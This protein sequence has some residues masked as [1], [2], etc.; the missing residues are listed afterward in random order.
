MGRGHPSAI[1]TRKGGEKESGEKSF[2]LVFASRWI[3]LPGEGGSGWNEEGGKAHQVTT[4]TVVAAAAHAH[5]YPA[6]EMKEKEDST[7]PWVPIQPRRTRE[8][9]VSDF[10]LVT[11]PG[12]GPFFHQGE[13]GGG[14]NERGEGK[15]EGE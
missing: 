1:S 14:G 12:E 4:I 10:T 15:R 3:A 9:R 5:T 8:E 13:R 2:S 6:E 11:S 7:S